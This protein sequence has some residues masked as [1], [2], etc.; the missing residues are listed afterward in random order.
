M[1]F[2]A[3]LFERYTT[4]VSKTFLKIAAMEAE[5]N[6]SALE[7][8]RE[9]REARNLE[10]PA[11]A[12]LMRDPLSGR[13]D[14]IKAAEQAALAASAPRS[15]PVIPADGEMPMGVR[16]DVVLA[17]AERLTSAERREIPAMLE[18]LRKDKK[19]RV[20]ELQMIC[21]K[22]LGEAPQLRKKPEH[23]AALKAQF[24]PGERVRTAE[25]VELQAAAG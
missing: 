24:G 3:D 8:Q 12:L 20:P 5:A 13:R 10:S 7:K 23:L 11:R 21:A 16:G 14:E 17:W 4:R 2:I 25:A 1:W 22:A 18:K 6:K 19:V 15:I 9:E